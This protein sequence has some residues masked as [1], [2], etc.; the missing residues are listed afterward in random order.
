MS[1]ISLKI[2]GAVRKSGT[3]LTGKAT[4]PYQIDLLIDSASDPSDHGKTS[5]CIYKVEGATLTIASNA[6]GVLT[7]PT[8]FAPIG[9]TRVF[10]LNE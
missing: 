6:P 9:G 2:Y 7:R 5:L 10:V 1:E 3:F 8:S 4:S